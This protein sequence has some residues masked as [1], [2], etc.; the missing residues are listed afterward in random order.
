M[1]RIDILKTLSGA[2]AVLAVTSCG[3]DKKADTRYNIVYIMTDDHT[4]QIRPR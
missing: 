1:T 4:A 3:P 2:A